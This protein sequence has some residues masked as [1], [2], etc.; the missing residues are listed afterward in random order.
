MPRFAFTESQLG[1]CAIVLQLSS[2]SRSMFILHPLG[3][4][5]PHIRPL[6]GL[7]TDFYVIS[8]RKA[9]FQIN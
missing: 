1:Y 4:S 5:R 9:G 6:D 7:N 3:N 8:L 2:L